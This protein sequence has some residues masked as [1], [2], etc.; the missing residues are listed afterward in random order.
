MDV[1]REVTGLDH[2]ADDGRPVATR[3]YGLT[4]PEDNRESF[5]VAA[6]KY[7]Y[8][9]RGNPGDDNDVRQQ[10]ADAVRRVAGVD[11][12]VLVGM[13]NYVE[14]EWMAGVLDGLDKP[15]LLDESSDDDV[16]EAVKREFFDGRGRCSSR[17]CAGR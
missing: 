17:R 13:P 8:A 7:T 3:T 11:G 15:V 10:Y 16:T 5:A 2:L 12:N 6:P 14:A 9:N 4:F 1:F